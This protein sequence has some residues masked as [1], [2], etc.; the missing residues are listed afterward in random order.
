MQYTGPLQDTKK[1]EVDTKVVVQRKKIKKQNKTT[2][3]FKR[4]YQRIT[5]V[6]KTQLL[7]KEN[8]LLVGHIPIGEELSNASHKQNALPEE[9]CPETQSEK[10]CCT[11]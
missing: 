11:F 2:E 9:D 6:A 7:L 4:L 8:K 10:L 1:W 3:S 5:S